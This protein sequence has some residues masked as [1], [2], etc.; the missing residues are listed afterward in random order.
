MG[1]GRRPF[2]TAEADASFAIVW[3]MVARGMSLCRMDEM[4][5]IRR[6]LIEQY[7]SND[8]G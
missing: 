8:G 2:C 4:L 5:F 1:F 3:R 7:N 6:L